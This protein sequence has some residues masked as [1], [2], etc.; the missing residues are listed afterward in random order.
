MYSSRAKYRKPAYI[1]LILAEILM[2]YQKQYY[3]T[4]KFV[5][6]VDALQTYS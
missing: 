3:S 4:Y 1:R 2:D 5:F 6:Q